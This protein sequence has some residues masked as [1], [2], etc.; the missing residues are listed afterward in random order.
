MEVLM[1][2]IIHHDTRISPKKANQSVD[3]KRCGTFCVSLAWQ[4]SK[5]S[6]PLQ[7]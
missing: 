5:V 1:L 7:I 3:R 6:L 4:T 2:T